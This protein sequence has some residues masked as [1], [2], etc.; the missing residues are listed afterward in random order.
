MIRSI[1]RR[2]RRRLL[3]LLRLDPAAVCQESAGMG[4]RDFHDY[5]DTEHGQPWHFVTLECKRC[6][7]MFTI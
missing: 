6:G 7:K 4:L 1:A 5:H 3:A 2:F